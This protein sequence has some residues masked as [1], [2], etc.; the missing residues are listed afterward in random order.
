M[1]TETPLFFFFLTQFIY[2]Y[3]SVHKQTNEYN[4]KIKC[5]C[6][7]QKLHTCHE[8]YTLFAMSYLFCMRILDYKTKCV[9]CNYLKNLNKCVNGETCLNLHRFVCYSNLHISIHTQLNA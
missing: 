9:F 6:K 1:H 8:I 7:F 3:I 2:N 5:V 4:L